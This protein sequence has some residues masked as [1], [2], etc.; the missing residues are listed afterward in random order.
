MNC[1]QLLVILKLLKYGYLNPIVQDVPVC[2]ETNQSIDLDIPCQDKECV[3]YKN[4][5]YQLSGE[6]DMFN[7]IYTADFEKIIVYSNNGRVYRTECEMIHSFDIISKQ[8]CSNY[9]GVNFQLKFAQNQGFLSKQ[10]I[11]RLKIKN[12]TFCKF[13]SEQTNFANYNNEFSLYKKD[14]KVAIA[15]RND[16]T[17]GIDFEKQNAIFESYDKVFAGSISKVIRDGSFL[18]VELLVLVFIVF[19]AFRRRRSIFQAIRFLFSVFNTCQCNR[20][21][22]MPTIAHGAELNP[23]KAES[24][25]NTRPTAPPYA[26]PSQ[27]ACFSQLYPDSRVNLVDPNMYHTIGNTL[28]STISTGH[29]SRSTSLTYQPRIQ[30]RS[31]SLSSVNEDVYATTDNSVPCPH[32]A[33]SFKNKRALA[34]HM[35]VHL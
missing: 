9:V 31:A 21:I 10:M 27:N 12:D 6:D 14:E 22:M 8:L 3:A 32:C 28:P 7:Y 20:K 13:S 33:K 34:G 11:I 17:I 2:R 25:P 15:A 24:Y 16:S 23:P 1:F 30:T 35:V 5:I 26:P 4:I 29:L 18:V 19:N